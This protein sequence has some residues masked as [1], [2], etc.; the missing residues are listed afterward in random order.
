MQEQLNSLPPEEEQ[1]NLGDLKLLLF[2]LS[3]FVQLREVTL[4]FKN[5]LYHKHLEATATH[6]EL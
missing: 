3:R 6:E 5:I 2:Q 4:S 1:C